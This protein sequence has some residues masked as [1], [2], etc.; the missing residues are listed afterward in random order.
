MNTNHNNN[1][2]TNIN[3]NKNNKNN[4][5]DINHNNNKICFI[6]NNVSCKKME[7]IVSTENKLA[8]AANK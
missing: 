2:N 5:T 7:K 3:H 1:N 6:N 8:K 4:N